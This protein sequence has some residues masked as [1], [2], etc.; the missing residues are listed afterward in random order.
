MQEDTLTYDSLSARPLPKWLIDQKE[1]LTLYKPREIIIKED[2]SLGISLVFTG[3][4]ILISVVI[5]T[6]YFKRKNRKSSE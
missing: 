2:H 3:L 5:L 1:G 4:F 6:L